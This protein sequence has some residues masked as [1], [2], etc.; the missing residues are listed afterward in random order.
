MY[1]RMNSPFSDSSTGAYVLNSRCPIRTRFPSMVSKS[2]M[3]LGGTYDIERGSIAFGSFFKGF[4]GYRR[5][6]LLGANYRREQ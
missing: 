1:I 2:I 4:G 5:R 3:C 6:S